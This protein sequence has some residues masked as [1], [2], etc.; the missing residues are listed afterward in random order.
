MVKVINLIVI[1]LVL[2]NLTQA[3]DANKLIAKLRA[4]YNKVKDFEADLK[5]KIDISFLNAPEQQGKIYFKQPNKSKVDIK[6]FNML[7]KQGSGNIIAELLNESNATIVISGKEKINNIENT[8]VKIIPNDGTKDLA[9]ATLWVNENDMTISKIESITKKSGTFNI[10]L[11]YIKVDNKYY[12]PSKVLIKLNVP[13]FSL[14]K[15]MTGE[16]AAKAAKKKEGNTEG[17]VTFTYFNYKVNKG[18][19]DEVFNAKK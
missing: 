12:L 8:V 13:N 19:K 14:P 4:E 1:L 6:G 5:V 17:K 15:S 11:E 2:L 16:N 10:F 9:V 18:I 3:Q 7:P